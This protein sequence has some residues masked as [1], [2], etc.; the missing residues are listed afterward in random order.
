MSLMTRLVVVNPATEE[1]LAELPQSTVEEIRA[2]IDKAYD[3]F[4]KW[5]ET[6]LKTRA[7]LLL[8]AAELLE[9]AG[10]E[11]VKTLVAES[12]KPIKDAEVELM[13]TVSIVRASAEEARFVL[14]GS[15]PRVDAYEYPLGNEERVVVELRE[16]VGVVGGAQSYN[17]PASTFAHKVAPV[18]AAGNTVIVKP[19]SYT[20]LTALKMAEIFRKA[21]FP[22]GVVNVV[23]GSGEEVF[24]ELID[25]PKVAG[26][27]FTG[28]TAVGL[29]VAAKAAGR[30]KKFMIAPGGSDPA[31]VFEDADLEAAAATIVRARFENAGQNCNATK[32]V[33]VHR[34]VYDKVV[35]LIV[36]KTAALKV[37][38][39][40]DPAT[41][42]G[43][44]ISD[45]MVKTMEKAVAEAREKGGKVLIGGE[46]LGRRGF[47]YAPT[48]IAFDGDVE[49]FVLRE[50]VFG[51]VL[52]V[53]P[54]DAE[55]EA[56]ALANA[57]KYGLQAA[58]YTRDYR[59]AMRVARAIK[60]GSVMVNDSTRVR[61][62]ALPYGGVKMSGL[63]WREGV[64]STMLYFTE[65]KFYVWRV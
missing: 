63:A 59:R 11:L 20:P 41:D 60:A 55:D 36:E 24:N 47:F 51:P 45:K 13:R 37:G 3:A 42:V 5:S 40:M 1:V 65:P 49:T 23:V 2:T 30:G 38:N 22:D 32:R 39:P 14:Q 29:Q 6:P 31:V 46:R 27:S 57:T 9:A 4:L 21:G 8:K 12:G 10:G 34:S 52:P 48:V 56:V 54:F 62:D 26:I 25:S 17:N 28:S 35:K 18:V 43:P 44:L 33:F 64:R 61:F 58:V 53:V 7:K 50:E 19:S 16:P 15:V